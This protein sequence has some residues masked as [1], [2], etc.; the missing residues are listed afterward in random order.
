MTSNFLN[1]KEVSNQTGLSVSA[2]R[3][4]REKN[5]GIPYYKLGKLVRY[6]EEDVIEFIE[7]CK[8]NTT[9]LNLMKGGD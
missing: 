8:V 5:F 3:K 7:N 6:K 2:L 4:H 1:E 9:N